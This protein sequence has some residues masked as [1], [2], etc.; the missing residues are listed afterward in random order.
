ML[1]LTDRF[2]PCYLTYRVEPEYPEEA[3]RSRIEGTVKIHLNIA[4]NGSVSSMKL[5]SGSPKL[6]PAAMEA[7]KYWQ[8]L[9]ALLNGQPVETGQDIEIDFRLPY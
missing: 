5:L 9:P 8:Y 7:A 1:K 4:A 6:A 3:L 2:N